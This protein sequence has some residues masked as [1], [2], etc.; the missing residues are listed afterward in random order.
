MLAA[1]GVA[2]PERHIA[3][4]H[5]GGV[6]TLLVS[7]SPLGPEDVARL[8]EELGRFEEAMARYL[9]IIEVEPSHAFAHVYIAAIHYLVY[10]RADESLV[11]YRKAAENDPASPSLQASQA[12]AYLELGDPGSAR[13]WVERGLELGPDTFWALWS[14]ALLNLY[15]GDNEA[16]SRDAR[17]LLNIY[18]GNWGGLRILRDAD[19]A[20]LDGLWD[21]AKRR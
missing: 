15:V 9:R 4:V 1:E 7:R 20:V 16:A 6:A 12:M 14:S 21:E 19:L 5:A 18:P 13:K 17:T 8:D 10:G 11:W 2:A 3:M